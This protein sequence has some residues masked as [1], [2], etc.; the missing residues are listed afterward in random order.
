MRRP[1]SSKNCAS[2]T[3]SSSN[4][5][6]VR[7]IQNVDA[8]LRTTPEPCRRGPRSRSWRERGRRGPSWRGDDRGTPR[9]GR[10]APRTRR[11]RRAGRR[12]G[13]GNRRGAGSPL[14]PRDESTRNLGACVAGSGLSGQ[15]PAFLR[16][17][18][19]ESHRLGS[20]YRLRVFMRRG[21]G[22][23]VQSR[24]RAAGFGAFP[25]FG[26]AHR[27]QFYASRDP[28]PEIL[29]DPRRL[30][31]ISFHPDIVMQNVPTALPE[32]KKR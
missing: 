20:E 13:R 26:I 1:S 5:I 6:P 2:E 17:S 27:C 12:G 15:R 30:F 7:A 25:S 21:Q 4:V 18:L 29:L 32:G 3:A 23:L 22:R 14:A 10:R 9:R 28:P 31:S 19:D 24:P 8:A 16:E 11:R